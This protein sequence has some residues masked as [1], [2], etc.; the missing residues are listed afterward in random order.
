MLRSRGRP[1]KVEN[2]DFV[3]IIVTYKDRIISSDKIV[4]KNDT[5]WC[6]ISSSL[7]GKIMPTSL[8]TMVTSNTH[9]IRDKLFGRSHDANNSTDNIDISADNINISDT[10]SLDSSASQYEENTK[11]INFVITVPNNEF[12]E[13][14]IFKSYKRTQKK[15]IRKRI[16]K[17]LR[18]GVWEDFITKKIW[19]AVKLKCGFRFRNHY[20]SNV[21]TSG[22]INGKYINL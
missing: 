9:G 2:Y 15:K 22:Y 10:T 11:A 3:N 21:G 16:W 6:D 18:P 20:L 14:I 13:L 19:D 5:I 17:T 1:H 12:E 7:G 4:S 8:Y